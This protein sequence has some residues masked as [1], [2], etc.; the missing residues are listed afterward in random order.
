MASKKH[1]SRKKLSH[2][3]NDALLKEANA[4]TKAIMRLEVYMRAAYS[5][6]AIGVLL[7]LWGF[8][9]SSQLG[10]GIAGIVCVALGVPAAIVLHTGIDHGKKNVNKMLDDYELIHGGKSPED[11]QK[12]KAV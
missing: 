8:V 11:D 2:D 10:W 4:Q 3:S 9:G 12:A 6:V 5:V 7:I 1:Q